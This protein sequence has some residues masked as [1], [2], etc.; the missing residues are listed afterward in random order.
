MPDNGKPGT[1]GATM[2]EAT[3]DPTNS[4]APVHIDTALIEAER[5]GRNLLAE[6]N[7]SPIDDKTTN[8]TDS[9]KQVLI[10]IDRL[11]A[12][13]ANTLA[14]AAGKLR[15]VLD[16]EVGLAAGESGKEI[17]G[18]PPGTDASG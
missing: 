17:G 14:G 9:G 3:D 16:P 13:P 6:A 1:Y 12:M 2:S 5:Q 11:A 10:M 18:W 7:K 15:I 8:A 4:G